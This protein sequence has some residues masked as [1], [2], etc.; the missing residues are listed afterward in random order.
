MEACVAANM[1]VERWNNPNPPPEGYSR[2][3][4]AKVVAFHTLKQQIKAHTEDE[5]I[6]QSKREMDKKRR[7]SRKTRARRARRRR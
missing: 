1:D 5:A 2:Q 6:E 3:L 4:K 7:G